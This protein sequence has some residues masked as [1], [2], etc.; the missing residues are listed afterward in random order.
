MSEVFELGADLVKQQF[1]HNFILQLADGIQTNMEDDE[2]EEDIA[3][4]AADFFF[5]L[6]DKTRIPNILL[7][8]IAWVLGEYGQ[9]A[10]GQSVH[11][12]E[13]IDENKEPDIDTMEVIR[14]LWEVVEKQG[15]DSE[16]R[17]WAMSATCKLCRHLDSVPPE[18]AEIVN[19]YTT[20]VNSELQQL[21][22]E[23]IELT[24]V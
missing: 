2:S 10:T 12:D 16:T 15:E 8:V 4:Y 6:L 24:K 20:S 22:H 23:L 3:Q 14:R 7:K 9:Y 21:S 19:K 1:A 17:Q 18:V 13:D 11:D 5:E